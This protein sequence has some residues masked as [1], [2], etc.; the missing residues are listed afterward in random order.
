[1]SIRQS[2]HS[3]K[4]L[5]DEDV[6]DAANLL[7]TIYSNIL[8]NPFEQKYQKLKV[9][10]L[11]KK[12][13][14]YPIIIEILCHSGFKKSNNNKKLIFNISRMKLLKKANKILT[15][16]F[17][18]KLKTNNISHI[19][20]LN[21]NQRSYSDCISIDKCDAIKSIIDQ[22]TFYYNNKN[23]DQILLKH[24]NNPPFDYKLLLNDY[25]H[26][27]MDHINT[28]NETTFQSVYDVVSAKNK[29]NI[30]TC[31]SSKRNRRDRTKCNNISDFDSNN[32]QHSKLNF[33]LEIM[34]TIHMY[35]VHAFD[36]GLRT[37]SAE[38]TEF[39]IDNNSDE[40][41]EKQMENKW[42]QFVKKK[43]RS[44]RK[45]L[46]EIVP[47]RL[48]KNNK[49]YTD[50]STPETNFD[51][52]KMYDE[53]KLENN[54]S[55][56]SLYSFGYP[57]HYDSINKTSQ[58]KHTTTERD[59][60]G[61]QYG[62]FYVAPKFSNL[63]DEML[64]NSICNLDIKSFA[65]AFLK[66]TQYLESIKAKSMVSDHP[67]AEM[68]NSQTLK[69]W[70][71][72]AIIFYT[73]FDVLSYNFSQSFR[74]RHKLESLNKVKQRHSEYANWSIII[75]RTIYAF[76]T[77]LLM[78]EQN[79][80]YHGTSYHEID[81]FVT[82]FNTPTS[83]TPILKVAAVFC[84]TKGMVMQLDGSGVSC[85]DVSWISSFTG[86]DERLFCHSRKHFDTLYLKNI[87][88]MN[89]DNDYRKY[90]H[91]LS[92]FNNVLMVHPN[93]K[94]KRERLTDNDY[95][96]ING[97]INSSNDYPGYVNKIFNNFTKNKKIVSLFYNAYMDMDASC[98]LNNLL[99][100]SI[101]VEDN[102]QRD[103]ELMES[104]K[105]LSAYYKNKE[106]IKNNANN[107][108][109][110]L[111]SNATWKQD[112]YTIPNFEQ[113]LAIFPNVKQ[114]TLEYHTLYGE[115]YDMTETFVKNLILG[116]EKV[117]RNII[118]FTLRHVIYEGKKIDMEFVTKFASNNWK[119]N[120]KHLRNDDMILQ[121]C[122][123]K[124]NMPSDDKLYG[125]DVEFEFLLQ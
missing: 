8:K 14:K 93:G 83:T 99:Y 70:H 85:F 11:E 92:M 74:K 105:K 22:L 23:N 54:E 10:D 97:L 108:L 2:I 55:Y 101:P 89:D 96:I 40:K 65:N 30:K 21:N 76:G 18:F 20:D 62:D 94:L 24:C 16:T 41:L 112:K 100:Q 59:F 31:I 118:H 36:C 116:I 13:D 33:Y 5:S 34:D 106:S 124:L 45:M 4:E 104:R 25:H 44:S 61:Y 69:V 7:H 122:I 79:N 43:I 114:I 82:Y 107:I 63:K 103:L 9:N 57:F 121:M 75:Y 56:T 90:I 3:L 102:L 42:V 98:P 72:M 19:S 27:I 109:S 53:E 86:E 66:A 111:N 80:Y 32:I 110:L 29:C 48:L 113:I 78:N 91:A 15:T 52:T 58:S 88:I 120:F 81:R 35:F 123:E 115:P 6:N 39:R 37:P 28:K 73:D 1:M 51:D 87:I 49:F 46:N 12:C 47:E 125:S 95:Q 71:L 77:C 117:S 50:V 38:L 17:K 64:N 60:F 67:N 26:I 119:I 68:W 84:N